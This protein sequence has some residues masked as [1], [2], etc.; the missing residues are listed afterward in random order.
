LDNKAKI[1]QNG[2]ADRAGKIEI[3]CNNFPIDGTLKVTSA[4]TLAF[5]TDYSTRERNNGGAFY[6]ANGV[7]NVP[8]RATKEVSGATPSVIGGGLIALQDD[9]TL[10]FRD[11]NHDNGRIYHDDVNFW[12]VR[13]PYTKNPAEVISGIVYDGSVSHAITRG[14]ENSIAGYNKDQP[15]IKLYRILVDGTEIDASLDDISNAGWLTTSDNSTHLF[16]MENSD[17]GTSGLVYGFGILPPK[18]E[19]PEIEKH[20]ADQSVN[21]G[22]VSTVTSAFTAKLI[23]TVN[24]IRNDPFFS[25]FAAHEGQKEE[26]GVAYRSNSFGFLCGLDFVDELKSSAMVKYGAA[27]SFAHGRTKFSGSGVGLGKIDENNIFFG[28]VFGGYE[29]Y[30]SNGMKTTLTAVST[31]GYFKT[32]YDRTDLNGYDY[33][34]KYGNSLFQ[35][36]GEFITHLADFNGIHVGPW[37][38]AT[39]TRTW[40]KRYCESGDAGGIIESDAATYNNLKTVLGLSFEREF[41]NEL[42]AER[43][44]RIF[45]KIGWRHEPVKSR[46]TNEVRIAHLAPF[47]PEYGQGKR[48]SMVA[49]IGF[50]NRINKNVEVLGSLN[51]SVNSKNYYVSVTASIGYSF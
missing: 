17:S 13:A 19:T 22:I 5:G 36:T 35:L 43:R 42:D 30:S 23:D 39:Y 6:K 21:V 14:D 45:A 25:V 50:R 34:A 15:K 7:I 24:D 29:N 2:R 32:K 27:A 26:K 40:Q 16:W 41:Q 33:S 11:V 10:A 48:N 1:F 28:S 44:V 8:L 46:S 49:T 37:A 18:P 31:L 4:Q 9:F 20:G 3:E 47:V 12:I 38:S 51:G